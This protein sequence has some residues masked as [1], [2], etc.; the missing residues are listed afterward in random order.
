M[1]EGS[2]YLSTSPSRP[3]TSGPWTLVPVQWCP[4]SS[5]TR[6]RTSHRCPVG[7]NDDVFWEG[8]E[9]RDPVPVS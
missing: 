4:V 6:Y 8:E 9:N 2:D 5:L 7:G 3:Y 1:G